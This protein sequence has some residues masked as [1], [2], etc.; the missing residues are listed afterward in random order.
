MCELRCYAGKTKGPTSGVGCGP[1]GK[2]IGGEL[3]AWDF[4]AL[5]LRVE[6]NAFVRFVVVDDVAGEDLE[7][8]AATLIEDL[9]AS[10]VKIL[11][12]FIG[13]RCL[14]VDDLG[15]DACAACAD[16]AADIAGSQIKELRSDLSEFA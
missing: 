10:L 9:V 11:G 1:D 7:C 2:S 8:F 14:L 5:G 13:A 16:G 4:R 15:H 12:N 3:F 6:E